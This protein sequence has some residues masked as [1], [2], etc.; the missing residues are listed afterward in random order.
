MTSPRSARS[1]PS[2]HSFDSASSQE[3]GYVSL[4][5]YVP[6]TSRWSGDFES[7]LVDFYINGV[8]PGRTVSQ[9]N[10]Y[11]DLLQ[12]SNTCESTRY[13]LLSLSASYIREYLT[14][15]KER[16]R[17]AEL[18][19]STQAFQAL[20]RQI[21]NGED[22]EAALSTAML[23]MHHSAVCDSDDASLC[24]SCHANIFNAIPT[25]F[26]NQ[27]SEPA[28]FMRNQLVL[29][30]T[31][32]TSFA[33]QNTQLHS[34]ETNNWIESSPTS[35]SQK[36]CGILGF[37]PELLY[38]ISSINSLAID[39]SPNRLMYAQL[40]EKKLQ[41]LRQWTSDVGAEVQEIMLATAEAFRIAA[42]IYLRCRLYGLTRFN[43]AIMELNDALTAV[44]L[45]LPVKGALYS[46]IYPVWP[47]FIA[48]VTAN[49][50]KRDRLYQ[51][52]VPIREG[53]KNTLPAVLKRVSGLRIWLAKQ[54]ASVQRREGWWEEMLQ[55]TSSTTDLSA[56][57]LLCL[58]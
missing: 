16:Y 11:I 54:D 40:Q 39:N 13:A 30:R 35:E 1:S 37:S 27:A 49:S 14:S 21:N 19:Y 34:L 55:P 12:T 5:K 25:E 6:D 58:G 53:D 50:D 26:I 23:L 47:V 48:A 9:S 20:V 10:T 52:V 44:L 42:L 41:N 15:D 51:R 32:Q 45:S 46:A 57:R 18:Y 28:L 2:V 43:P 22:Y 38:L 8:C 24:W 56:S 7:L 3:S 33:L 4:I 29:A 36:I 17:Q 31:A